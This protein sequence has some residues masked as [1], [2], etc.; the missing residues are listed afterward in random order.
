MSFSRTSLQLIALVLTF[1]SVVGAQVASERPQT[2]IGSVGSNL[3]KWM[4][5]NAGAILKKEANNQLQFIG[6]MTLTRKAESR[7]AIQSKATLVSFGDNLEVGPASSGSGVSSITLGG[8]ASLNV[9]RKMELGSGVTLSLQGSGA[10][11][12]CES[13][14]VSF[15]AET[16]SL[17]EFI[18]DAT[19]FTPLSTTGSLN[20]GTGVTLN[21]NATALGAGQYPLFSF[22]GGTSSTNNH[23]NNFVL[24]SL[25]LAPG[26]NGEIV[27]G[28][29]S[30]LLSIQQNAPVTVQAKVFHSGFTGSATPHWDAI[31]NNKQ[32]ARQ[33]LGIGQLTIDNIINSSHGLNGLVFDFENQQ[34]VDTLSLQDFEF[35]ISPQGPFDQDQNPPDQWQFSAPPS[36]F[37][38]SQPL[39]G[40][41]R[42]LIKWPNNVIQNR[43]LRIVVRATPATGL[44]EPVVFFIG[45]LTGEGTGVEDSIF[46]VSFQDYLVIRSELAQIVG[47]GSSK[48]IDKNGMVQFADMTTMRVALATQL[49]AITIP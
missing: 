26:F 24:G 38:L 33:G 25:Q 35:Q 22:S 48:D 23:G 10:E 11:F 42:A 1:K 30:I 44:S 41:N 46:S 34:N 8:N 15:L 4:S 3:G 21:V 40:V 27:Y 9:F 17:V 47:A 5:D 13:T 29:H 2:K 18:A 45:H 43:W 39:A 49:P 7:N 6:G 36:A 32:L 19:G 20:I 12:I 37:T 14:L 31:D 16:G 28:P